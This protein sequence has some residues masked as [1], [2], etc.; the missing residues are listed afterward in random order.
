MFLAHFSHTPLTD[1][2]D[3]ELPELNWW[4]NE[5]MK[6]HKKFNPKE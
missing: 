4:Y 3:M 5:A 2:M 1:L 6:L